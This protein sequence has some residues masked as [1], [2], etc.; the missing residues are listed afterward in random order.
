MVKS[1]TLTRRTTFISCRTF[2]YMQSLETDDAA[3]R[4]QKPQATP[5]VDR[6]KGLWE[7][8]GID[9]PLFIRRDWSALK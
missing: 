9:V 3:A 2:L 1:S 7:R 4:P 8:G 5:P 6:G